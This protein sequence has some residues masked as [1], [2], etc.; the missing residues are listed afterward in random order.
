M[1]TRQRKRV[2]IFAVSDIHGHKQ[3]LSDALDKAGFS[4]DNEGHLLVVIGDL[5]DRGGENKETLEYLCKIK[6]KILIRGNHE[7]ILMETLTSGAVGGLQV[8]N[9]TVTTLMSFFENYSGGKACLPQNE[10]ERAASKKLISLIDSM[11]CYFETEN[12]IFTHGWLPLKKEQINRDWRY[13]KSSEWYSARWARWN[14]YYGSSEISESKTLVIGH[15]SAS[16]ANQFEPER[17]EDCF[18]IFHADK[19]IAIDGTTVVSGQVNV[20]VLEDEIKNPVCLDIAVDEVDFMNVES[21][22]KRVESTIFDGIAKDILPLDSIKYHSPSGKNVECKVVS[23]HKYSSFAEL[24]EE[25][26]NSE[27]G[28]SQEDKYLAAKMRKYFSF[29]QVAENGVLAIF[30]SKIKKD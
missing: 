4:S 1:I 26:T 30:F 3:Q 9:G 28:V 7:D 12:Y 17:S 18:D 21:G 2:K 19:M 14:K 5:F 10:K 23:L 6:N 13:A 11:I 8:K 22:K 15:T 24:E 25:F 20:L 29:E 16:Y 27:L